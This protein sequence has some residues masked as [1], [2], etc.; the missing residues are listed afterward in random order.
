MSTTDIFVTFGIAFGGLVL[1]RLLFSLIGWTVGKVLGLL[2]EGVLVGAIYLLGG[3]AWLALLPVRVIAYYVR[4]GAGPA[5]YRH[6]VAR[7]RR[8]K[9]VR[10]T[11]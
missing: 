9:E 5:P 2:I 1:M 6:R 8:H 3:I 7:V 4:G 10:S 11:E